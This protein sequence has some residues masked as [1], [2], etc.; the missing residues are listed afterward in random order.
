MSRDI[1]VYATATLAT[2]WCVVSSSSWIT[3]AS[4]M[5]LVLGD[6]RGRRSALALDFPV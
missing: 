6:S 5:D 4:D 1:E 3:L 2:W